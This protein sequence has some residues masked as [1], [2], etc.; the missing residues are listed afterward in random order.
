M[1]TR[2]SHHTNKLVPK[3]ADRKLLK[4]YSLAPIVLKKLILKRYRAQKKR[5]KSWQMIMQTTYHH[6]P[7]CIIRITHSSRQVCRK[8]GKRERYQT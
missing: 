8:E 4:K 7:S 2:N 6:Y 3:D 1:I 5:E